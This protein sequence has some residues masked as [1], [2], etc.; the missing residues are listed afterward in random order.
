MH[1]QAY[2]LQMIAPLHV[3]TKGLDKTDTLE[4]FPSSTFFSALVISWL[5]MGQ[6]AWVDAFELDNIQQS[7]PLQITSAFPYVGDV[8]F[9]P[10]PMLPI[11]L[12]ADEEQPSPVESSIAPTLDKKS[13]RKIRWISTEIFKAMLEPDVR[14][15]ELVE[16]GTLIQDNEVLMTREEE[17]R[18]TD[19]LAFD[20]D[21]YRIWKQPE[22]A[23]VTVDR[24]TGAGNLHF[25]GSTFFQ[26]GS[27]LWCMGRSREPEW[28]DHL[29]IALG[30]LAD[31]GIGGQRSKGYGRFELE[32]MPTLP[33]FGGQADGEYEILLS[34]TAPHQAQMGALIAEHSRYLLHEVGG[35]S[36][37]YPY[38][39]QRD[40]PSATLRRPVRMLQ[41][42]SVIQ[43]QSGN[44]LTGRLLN[45]RANPQDGG[46]IIHL[47]GYGYGIPYQPPVADKIGKI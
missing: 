3:G 37:S 33:E 43:R 29:E 34:R 26:P 7:P 20:E 21:T 13:A 9:L 14:I 27:G 2:K 42:G 11:M 45:V 44:L 4:Y 10:R 19:I 38:G 31:S 39:Q 25:V 32:T 1:T 15:N 40:H 18:V 12:E 24:R 22:Q 17:A 8:F 46:H 36:V 41:E 16:A 35:F 5:E 47:Y 30:Y 23:H 6:E 28:L